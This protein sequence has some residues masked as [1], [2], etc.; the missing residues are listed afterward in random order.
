MSEKSET[1]STPFNAAL[2]KIAKASPESS[3]AAVQSAN[4]SKPS[5]HT[6]FVLNPAKAHS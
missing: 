1:Y 3:R 2:E 6:R 4:A 5:L